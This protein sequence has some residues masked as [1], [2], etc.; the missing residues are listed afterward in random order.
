[1]HHVRST[2]IRAEKVND[3]KMIKLIKYKCDINMIKLKY[4]PLQE[5]PS[6]TEID[7]VVSASHL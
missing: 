7:Q 5:M 3:K 2:L 6:I 4:F 1:M